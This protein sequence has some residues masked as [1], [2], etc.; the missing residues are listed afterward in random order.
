MG[1]VARLLCLTDNDVTLELLTKESLDRNEDFIIG[2]FN[3]I[4]KL[5]VR[6]KSIS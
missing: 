6:K 3:V 5:E 4:K 1:D 2:M